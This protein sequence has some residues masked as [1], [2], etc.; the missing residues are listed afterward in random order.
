LNPN[1][2]SPEYELFA[3]ARTR[4]EQAARA[5]PGLLHIETVDIA[6]A[7]VE[8]RLLGNTLAESLTET[9]RH[10]Q[11][12]TSPASPTL[13][14]EAWAE[15]ETGE[16]SL[17]REFPVTDGFHAKMDGGSLA[18]SADDRFLSYCVGANSVSWLDRGASRIVASVR[19]PDD[20]VLRECVKPFGPLIPVW[21]RDRGVRAMHAA[22]VGD[23]GRVVLLL[24]ASGAGKSTCATFCLEAGMEYLGDDAVALEELADGR[25]MAHSLYGGARLWPADGGLL[26]GWEPYAVQP[27][28]CGDDPKL[29]LFVGRRHRERLLAQAEVAAIAFPQIT[30]GQQ[31]RLRPLG[32]A[33]VLRELIRTSLFLSVKPEAQ[34]LD[35]MLRLATSLPAHALELGSERSE[36]PA[37]VQQC[38]SG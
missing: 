29:L 32:R 12:A 36:I 28:G 19:R 6:G 5:Q 23:R 35:Q 24:G 22:A 11:T 7:R 9:F 18:I 21:L 33:E 8:M 13:Q 37:L 30:R 17:P 10:L 3:A 26:P 38:L 15:S 25:F 2:Q 34:D 4:F 1:A 31:S 16:A 14:I 20:L 27:R